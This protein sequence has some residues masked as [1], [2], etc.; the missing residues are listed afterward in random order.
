MFEAAGGLANLREVN[1][2]ARVYDHVNTE[3]LAYFADAPHFG[4]VLFDRD[5]RGLLDISGASRR[6]AARWNPRYLGE[7]PQVASAALA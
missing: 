1:V 3:F 6:R 4:H 7:H 5:E 2:S